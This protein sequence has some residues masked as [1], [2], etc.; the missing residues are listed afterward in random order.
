MTPKPD[1]AGG[2]HIKDASKSKCTC[3]P[4]PDH[5][6]PDCVQHGDPDPAYDFEVKHDTSAVVREAQEWLERTKQGYP[7]QQEPA[8]GLVRGLLEENKTLV[9]WILRLKTDGHM[10]WS[11]ILRGDIVK[12]QALIDADATCAA[13]REQVEKLTYE[14]L[15]LAVGPETP[16]TE[17]EARKQLTVQLQT[18]EREVARLTASRDEARQADQAS[19]TAYGLLM[20][21]FL[22]LHATLDALLRGGYVQHKRGCGHYAMYRGC[23]CGLKQWLTAE[24]D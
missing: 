14:N 8:Y 1:M 4:T 21:R 7:G 20:D 6:N 23:D 5:R 17:H 18:A 11:L 12:P 19:T 3:G 15:R 2:S 24:R 16:R 22:A 13:L 10:V 9:D